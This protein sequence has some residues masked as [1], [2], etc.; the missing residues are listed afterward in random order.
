MPGVQK[1]VISDDGI[2]AVLL[3]SLRYRVLTRKARGPSKCFIC[4]SLCRVHNG[5]VILTL[6]LS[7]CRRRENLHPESICV[8][9][10]PSHST[11]DEMA[12]NRNVFSHSSGGPSFISKRQQGCA[13]KARK[14]RGTNPSLPLLAFR[15]LFAILRIPRCVTASL[16][17]LPL[18][19]HFALCVSL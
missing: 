11:T 13:L 3:F 10:L 18:P 17:S 8:L 19:S 15:W 5:S 1:R 14:A 9:G 16:Q 7:L 12:Y 2:L 4:I 6:W